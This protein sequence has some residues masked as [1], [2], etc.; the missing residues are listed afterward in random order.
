MTQMDKCSQ[1]QIRKT[2]ANYRCVTDTEHYVKVT[3]VPRHHCTLTCLIRSECSLIN[4]NHLDHN[5]FMTGDRCI[6][7]EQDNGFEIIYY[8]ATGESCLSWASLSQYQQSLAVTQATSGG[9]IVVG[10]YVLPTDTIPGKLYVK[11]STLYVVYNGGEW[12]NNPD[13]TEVLQVEPECQV[14][15]MNYTAGSVI[16]EGAVL[17]GHTSQGNG[18]DFFVI[19]ALVANGDLVFGYY[20]TY[21]KRGHI[22]DS[23]AHNI[24]NMEIMLLLW[25]VGFNNTRWH[26]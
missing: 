11:D 25:F 16:P 15:W 21:S 20:D 18:S 26:D 7:M 12:W 14:V 2:R 6:R 19:R 24:T 10:R 4:Y 8:G 17:G 22:A 3:S 23:G 9:I 1:L 13:P 5:C